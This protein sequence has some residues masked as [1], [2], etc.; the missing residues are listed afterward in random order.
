M[1]LDRHV[2]TIAFR[3][4]CVNLRNGNASQTHDAHCRVIVYAKLIL[5]AMNPTLRK[6]LLTHIISLSRVPYLEHGGT[7]EI[8]AQTFLIWL[9]LTHT[10]LGTLFVLYLLIGWSNRRLKNGSE[11]L[12]AIWDI[13]PIQLIILGIIFSCL[14]Y[15]RLYCKL[16]IYACALY[17]DNSNILLIIHY[18]TLEIKILQLCTTTKVFLCAVIA[19]HFKITEINISKSKNNFVCLQTSSGNFVTFRFLNWQNNLTRKQYGACI[20][21]GASDVRL[22]TVISQCPVRFLWFYYRFT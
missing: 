14:W 15:W 20:Q 18:N 11:A 5:T 3:K 6:L 12:K 22:N 7:G 19:E 13:L 8:T 21:C 4:L 16:Q 17:W 10:K 1:L 2:G 9:R